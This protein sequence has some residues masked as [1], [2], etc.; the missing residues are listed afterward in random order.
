MN[1]EN[2][3]VMEAC[4]AG[5]FGGTMKFPDIVGRLSAIGV[6]RY[7]ADYSRGDFTYYTAD[8]QSH[9]VTPGHPTKPVGQSFSAADVEKAIRK[10]QRG[11]IDFRQFV[12]LT[13]AAGCVGYFVQISGRQAIYF[14]RNGETHVEPFPIGPRP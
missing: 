11:E 1:P 4:V 13:T 14:G 6:E 12:D 3:A 9:V 7:H 5:S 2:V 10:S 8:G